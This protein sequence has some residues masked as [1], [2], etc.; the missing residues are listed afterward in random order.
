M[1]DKINRLFLAWG[2]PDA[3][4]RADEL[5]DTLASE[6]YYADPNAPE[7][8]TDADAFVAYVA[9]FTQYAPGATARVAKLTDCKGH[10]RATVIFE[11]ADGKQ[12]FGQ[13]FVDLSDDGRVARMIGFAG[14]GEPD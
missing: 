12:Q 3:D 10:Y 5:K 6:F 14:L 8:I 13:Y 4:S 1:S 9:M 7:P 11:M 2:N